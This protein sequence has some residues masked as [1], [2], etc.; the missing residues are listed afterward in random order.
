MGYRRSCEVLLAVRDA[1]VSAFG[2]LV[3]KNVLRHSAGQLQVSSEVRAVI[4]EDLLENLMGIELIDSHEH[5]QA[6][7]AYVCGAYDFFDLL[8]KDPWAH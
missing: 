6:E 4:Y 5:F 8:E 2:D 1:R 3:D 7:S